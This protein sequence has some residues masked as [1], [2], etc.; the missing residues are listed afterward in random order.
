M[1]L[2]ATP[3]PHH[4]GHGLRGQDRGGARSRGRGWVFAKAGSSWRLDPIA[5]NGQPGFA[6]YRRGDSGVFE[7][8]T[9]QVFTVTDAGISRTTVFQD[10]E[11]F[12]AFGLDTKSES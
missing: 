8:H 11:V 9:L 4:V 12:A 2:Q 10:I 7:L 3:P 1:L 5:A 6:A